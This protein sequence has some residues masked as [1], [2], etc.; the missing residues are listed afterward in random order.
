MGTRMRPAPGTRVV[1][2]EP[3]SGRKRSQRDTPLR[4]LCAALGMA[5]VSALLAWGFRLGPFA[6]WF[7]AFS[8]PATL[9]L[10]GI[11][12]V[13]SHRRGAEVLRAT[14]VAGV[15]GGLLG[16]FGYDA[17]RVLEL[18]LGLRPYLPID[19]YGLL[20]LNASHSSGL[21]E[22]AGWG[23]NV[24]NG[25]GF[26]VTYAMLARGRPWWWAIPYAF[27]LETAFVV[28]PLSGLYQLS[29]HWDL[30][31]LAYLAHVCYAYPLGKVVQHTD[32]FVTELDAFSR[33]STPIALAGVAAVLVAW[34]HPWT[35]T[36]AERSGDALGVA[37]MP[38]AVIVAGRFVPEWLRVAPGG[39]VLLR[40]D[41]HVAHSLT[42]ARGTPAVQP[43]AVS[44][45]CVDGS[46][47]VRVKTANTPY[48]GGIVFVDPE[49][50]AT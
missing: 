6:V 27:V 7:W 9:L 23:F 40:D 3:V 39:C 36:A 26:G 46:G 43:G 32:A 11:A 48:A 24:L 44:R 25:I 35:S 1:L 50:S 2:A 13:V 17:V 19:S 34:H 45:V 28:T 8:A 16:T 20:A 29:G 4:V 30:I 41:D 49:L 12:V 42:G 10:A 47:V 14:L 21:S 18:P 37:G 33:R 22:L 31:A 5:S 38:G 15:A